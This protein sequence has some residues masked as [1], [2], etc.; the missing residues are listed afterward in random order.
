MSEQISLEQMIAGIVAQLRE[1]LGVR[2]KTLDLT[3][4]NARHRLPRRIYR[5]ALILVQAEP[6]AGH[7]KL[8]L[9][10]NQPTLVSAAQEVSAH[11]E[12]IDLAD[13]RKGWWLGLLGG[14]SFNLILAGVLLTVFLVWRG[15]L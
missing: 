13:Q 9:T 10:L 3:V 1:K 7:P 15:F 2:G 4:T 6:L 14:L 11:L 5:Q 8:R 12:A